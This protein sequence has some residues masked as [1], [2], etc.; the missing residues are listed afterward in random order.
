M[1]KT[2]LQQDLLNLVSKLEGKNEL[3]TNRATCKLLE[4]IQFIDNEDDK[5]LDNIHAYTT[6]K[7]IMYDLNKL[8]T[9]KQSAESSFSS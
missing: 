3:F 5:E 4:L 2:E 1:T 9:A 6:L 7:L 8:S